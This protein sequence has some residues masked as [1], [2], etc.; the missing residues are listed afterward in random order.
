MRAVKLVGPGKL[1]VLDVPVPE[2]GDGEVLVKVGAA[3]LCHS[4]L[5][6]LHQGE[7]WPFFGTTMGHETAGSVAAVGTN[8][9]DFADGDAIL[10]RALWSCGTC[11]PCRHLRDN[12][13]ATT[14]TRTTFPLTPGIG[15]DGGMADYIKVKANHLTKIGAL[16]PVAAAPLADAGL[17]PMHAINGVREYL[18]DDASVLVIGVG[19]L[20]HVALQILAATATSTVIAVD[21][22]ARK[23]DLARKRGATLA[24]D[25]GPSTAREILAAVGDHGVDVVLDFVGL[26]Q[27][28]DL[29]MSV[30]GPA[31]AMRIVGLGGGQAVVHADLGGEPLPWGVTVQRPYGGTIADQVAVID[32]ANQGEVTIETTTYP[33]EEAQRAFDDLADGKVEGRAVLVP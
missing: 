5:H 15:A 30:V 23:R 29:G 28:I 22:E 10:V 25:A 12:A 27:T 20:G 3:S 24:L 7:D 1:D 17:T 19:G 16:D 32:L 14:A 2:I 18:T 33:L 4:D 6:I 9:A 21:T 11:R 13:C 26:Q 8:V 31:G